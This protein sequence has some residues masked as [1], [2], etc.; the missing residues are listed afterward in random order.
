[1]YKYEYAREALKLGLKLEA[2]LGVN[3]YKFG[4]V[5]STDS[6][7]AMATAEEDN[8]FGKHSGKEPHADRWKKLERGQRSSRVNPLHQRAEVLGVQLM[9]EGMYRCRLYDHQ[10]HPAPRSPPIPFHGTCHRPNGA[11]EGWKRLEIRA[12]AISSKR[13]P[14]FPIGE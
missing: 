11:Q 5:G 6:H 1:M 10:P 13:H 7:T 4:M 3:P 14:P 12:M 9:A 2:K 8:F